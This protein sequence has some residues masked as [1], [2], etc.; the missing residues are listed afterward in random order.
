MRKLRRKEGARYMSELAVY[1]AK[2]HRLQGPPAQKRNHFRWK[3]CYLPPKYF[4]E[5]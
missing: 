1:K 5:V 4:P 2:D 3:K